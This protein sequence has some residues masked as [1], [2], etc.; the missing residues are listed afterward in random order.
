MTK[1]KD[2][3]ERIEVIIA[4]LCRAFS[5]EDIQHYAREKTKWKGG[6]AVIRRYLTEARRQI[7]Q[8]ADVDIDYRLGQSIDRLEDLYKRS[9]AMKDYDLALNIQREINRLLRLKILNEEIAAGNAVA[10][11]DN[12]CNEIMEQ[13]APVG[14]VNGEASPLDL[15]RRAGIALATT[16]ETITQWQPQRRKK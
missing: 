9:Y 15:I 7:A 6:P 16:S 11:L 14:P 5:E 12:L 3:P 13:L 4:L 1:P 8:R 10:E 2:Y